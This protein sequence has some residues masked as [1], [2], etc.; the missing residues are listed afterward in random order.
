MT[1]DTMAPPLSDDE[2]GPLRSGI[3]PLDEHAAVDPALF[4]P[5]AGEPPFARTVLTTPL[6]LAVAA[7]SRVNRW[8]R[9]NGF[10]V[11][12]VLTDLDDEYRALRGAAAL[13]DISP[14]AKY[15][16]AGRDA[17]VYLDRLVTRDL[18]LLAVDRALHVHFCEEHG[19]VVGD[20][21]LFRLGDDEYRL[22][23]EETHL[24][25]LMD[26]AIGLR[27]R[28]EDVGDT[29]AAMSLQ[30]PLAAV[31]LAEAGLAG[32]ERLAPMAGCWAAAAGMPVYVSRTGTSGD[33]GYE[34]WVD[35]DDAPHV[36]RHLTDVGPPFG[37]RVSGFR[38]RELA[39]LEA[40]FAR[41]GRDYLGA[42]AAIDPAHARTP[43]ELGAGHHVDFDKPFFNGRA[44]L[45]RLAA[46]PARRL[47]RLAV[48]GL[49]PARFVGVHANGRQVGIA[50]TS[51][52]SPAR[53]QN[54][55]LAT[56]DAGAPVAGLT[57]D[58]EIRDELTPRRVSLPA[59]VVGEPFWAP[60]R[61]RAVPAPL[62]A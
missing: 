20:G 15:R 14:L 45:A 29:L 57:V 28:V 37:L 33:L 16:I 31:C 3:D 40:G 41:A 5:P 8:T 46:A 49:E 18:G 38:L 24:A 2:T 9:W 1:P 36:W 34:I 47:V 7:E 55:A 59:R 13:A 51:G 22:V 44:A 30:G 61:R 19:L 25:W 10:T 32:I 50:T 43:F 62:T 58:A 12:S 53:G 39:R 23:T 27:V 60:A 4:E 54:I 21:L 17:H 48:E 42:F 6:H 26:S 56:L 52:F 11:A 35:P